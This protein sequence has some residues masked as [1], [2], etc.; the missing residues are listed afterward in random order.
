[1][2][3]LQFLWFILVGVLFSGFFFL[4]GFD[5]GVGM[6]IKSL[7][8]TRAERDVVI[9][10]IGP[11]WDANEVWLITAGGAMFASF[12]MWYASLFSGF[13]LILLLILK[14]PSLCGESH[15]NLEV[16]WKV[17]PAGISGNG[18]QPL[19]VSLLPSCSG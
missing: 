19:A 1:M 3:N 8:Q 4:E 6:T 5:F 10:T 16:G 12:P 2:S 17:T 18:L 9:H 13:Y 7:A 11:H 15:L 14:W